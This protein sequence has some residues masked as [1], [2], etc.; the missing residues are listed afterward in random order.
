MFLMLIMVWVVV[1]EK[2]E[3]RSVNTMKFQNRNDERDSLSTIEWILLLLFNER[4]RER[5]RER[6]RRDLS[7]REKDNVSA[8]KRDQIFTFDS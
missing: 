3:R 2:N 7:D 8:T 1:F 6:A 5:E 4:E